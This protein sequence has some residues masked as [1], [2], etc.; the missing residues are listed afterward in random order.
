MK[1]PMQ[2]LIDKITLKTVGGYTYLLPIISRLELDLL[3][4]K[5][6]EA[7]CKFQELSQ[8]TDFWV[9]YDGSEDCFEKTFN[10]KEK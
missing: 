4:E 3:L 7:M 8:R 6:K 5:E 9:E 2:E 1:T 10:T